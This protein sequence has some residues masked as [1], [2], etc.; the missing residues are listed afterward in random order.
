MTT[1]PISSST[2]A[3]SADALTPRGRTQTLDQKDFLKLLVAQLTTQDPLNPQKDTEFIGQMAQFSALE[4]SKSLQMEMQ[5]LRANQLLGQTVEVKIN[6]QVNGRGV[7]TAIDSSSGEP[8]I[9]IG[10]QAY[11]LV[12]IVRIDQPQPTQTQTGTQAQTTTTFKG[13]KPS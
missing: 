11:S 6:D 3:T 5:T 9:M 1:D 13:Y 4:N 8:K 12:D 2:I 10:K 7:V